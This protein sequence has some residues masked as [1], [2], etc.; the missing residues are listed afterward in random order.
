MIIEGALLEFI[1]VVVP[2]IEEAA[3]SIIHLET[4]GRQFADDD[5]SEDDD[6]SS[7]SRA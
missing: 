5:L 1:T 7:D 6:F 4:R 2:S 3:R